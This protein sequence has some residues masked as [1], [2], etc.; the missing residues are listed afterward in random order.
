[1][2]RTHRPSSFAAAVLTAAMVLAP[3]AAWAQP[4][5]AG[6]GATAAAG[7]NGPP[8][9]GEDAALYSCKK[10]HGKVKVSFKPDTQL[11]D[12][13]TWV[14]GFTCKN[15]I[16][17][18]SI[19][20]RSK[21]ITIISPVSMS[22]P[23]AY[24]VFLVALSTMGLTVVP[25]G[26]VLRIVEAGQA[27]SES[28]PI[29]RHGMPGNSDDMVRAIL[30]PN[31]LWVTELNN[32]LG[33]IKSP[34]GSLQPVAEA[35]ALIVTDYASTVRSMGVVMRELDRPTPSANI[36]TIKVKYANAKEMADKLNE[37]LGLQAQQAAARPP[38]AGPGPAGAPVRGQTTV[39]S[40][41]GEVGS[42]G[43]R[44]RRLGAAR[45]DPVRRSDEHV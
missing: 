42:V 29:Y 26:N 6:G 32:A 28:L 22:A 10:A 9:A 5:S 40:S 30:R 34:V 14:M 13:I 16:Y 20:S 31:Y 18:A 44:R 7:S 33:G 4:R 23:Q 17:D 19:T 25:K 37:I 38:G 36:Y 35:N 24:R 3:A 15:F 11:S 41:P 43:R 27:K 45:Q 8:V 21:K 12:L 39:G 1:M 2:Q